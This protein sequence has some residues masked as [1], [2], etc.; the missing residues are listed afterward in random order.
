[1]SEKDR[2]QSLQ[3]E[4]VRRGVTDVKFFF[5][6]CGDKPLTMVVHQISDVL[7]AY[8]KGRFKPMQRLEDVPA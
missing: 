4:L 8:L 7:D 2:L 5:S 1:M 6:A 3:A